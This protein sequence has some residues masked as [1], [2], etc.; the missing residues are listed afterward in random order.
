M[1]TSYAYDAIIVG[2]GPN[3]L[4]AAITLAR[5]GHSVCVYEAKN[6][7]GGGCRSAEVTLPGFTHDI[8]SA[9]HPMG[10]A[11]PFLRSLPLTE[12]GL[13][14]VHP[15]HPLAHPLADGSAAVLDRSIETTSQTLKNDASA[16]RR[17]MR[18]L[19]ENWDDIVDSFVGP[20]RPL[21]LLRHPFKTARFGL[22]AGLP[23]QLTARALFRGRHARAL[24]A[25]M[26]AH[27]MLSLDKLT[28]S[29][30][31]LLL[32]ILGH[33]VGW[34]M[35]RGGSQRIIDA[36][37]AYLR[38]LGGELITSHEVTSLDNLPPS[39]IVIC[40]ITPR[41]LLRISGDRISGLYKRQ[42]QRYRYGP[43]SFKIDFALD[44]PIPWKAQDC[45][46]AGTIHLGGTLEE[47]A[48]SEYA[49]NHNQ[50]PERPYMIVAQQSLFDPT[51]APEGKQTAWAYCHVP[52]GSDFDMTTR[53]EAQI[54]RFAP[55]FR[56]RILARHVTSA[57]AL[58]RYNANY[59]GGD[60]NGGIQ[61][62][63]QFFTRPAIQPDPYTTSDP[64]LFLCSSST[65]PGGGVH[66][67]CGYFAAQ[68]ALRRLHTHS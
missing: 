48:A 12:Y 14:W 18:P 32:G 24:L 60:I 43:G 10:M 22:P 59:V 35:A 33:A 19:V 34:P 67:L 42:L 15:T 63:W 50:H 51:R 55:G 41:Q 54:E 68:T 9:I 57:K 25:G 47:I 26:S 36:M 44:G 1:K 45:H 21:S 31:G 7:I 62:L 56:D 17:F 46:K 8:C 4:A 52:H 23:S 16:Y 58:E 28:S 5:A 40:D 38:V 65:P 20:L 6:T 2:S 29:G 30:A 64:D 49:V 13:T 27:S 66:G 53:M 3:G 11:S 61:D 39:K 37:A